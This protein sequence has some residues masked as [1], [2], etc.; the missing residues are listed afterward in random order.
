MPRAQC[1]VVKG[2]KILMA[3]H[4]ENNQE[5]WCLPSGSI[6]M[7]ELPAESALQELREECNVIGKIVRETSVVTYN[8]SCILHYF[9]PIRV[10]PCFI[11]G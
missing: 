11:R 4:C 6:E 8:V 5:Y 9:L 2:L 10:N 1:L 3:K 7:G